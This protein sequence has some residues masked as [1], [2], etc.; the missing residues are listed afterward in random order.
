[1]DWSFSFVLEA[2]LQAASLPDFVAITPV[3]QGGRVEGSL[4]NIYILCSNKM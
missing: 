4:F 3:N 1:M 2:T